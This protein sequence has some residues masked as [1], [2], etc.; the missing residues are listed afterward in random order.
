MHRHKAEYSGYWLSTTFP[1]DNEDGE[2]ITFYDSGWKG[3][4][5]YTAPQ[6]RTWDEFISESKKHGWPSFRDSEVNW[7]YVRVLPGGEMVSI[8]GTHLGHNLP[9]KKGNRYCISKFVKIYHSA[10]QYKI[11]VVVFVHCRQKK[12]NTRNNF[13]SSSHA[14]SINIFHSCPYVPNYLSLSVCVCFRSII[15]FEKQ[16]DLTTIAGIPITDEKNNTSY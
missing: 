16:I 15:T 1:M 12:I 8:D 2:P 6:D 3:S 11:V 14:I 7:D 13:C 4:P 5:L 10:T 9:D